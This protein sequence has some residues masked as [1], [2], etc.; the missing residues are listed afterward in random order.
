MLSSLGVLKMLSL[1]SLTRLSCVSNGN[2][3]VKINDGGEL[4]NDKTNSLPSLCCRRSAF[5]RC[6][7]SPLSLSC[8][9]NGNL[10]AKI[11]DGGELVNDKTDSLPSL[12]CRRS[13]FSRCSLSPLSLSCVSNGNLFVKIDDGAPRSELR[14]RPDQFAAKSMLS[15]LGVLKI[16]EIGRVHGPGA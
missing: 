10:L 8:V 4:V 7:L 5:S 1:S 14:Q 9:S 2:L 11:N 6:S 12:C 3:L 15:S 16:G 13:A